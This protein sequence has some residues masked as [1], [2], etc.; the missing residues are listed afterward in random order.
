M[1]FSPP[2]MSQKLNQLESYESI[3]RP[4]LYN[5]C[6]D[7][8][9]DSFK[10]MEKDFEIK[11]NLK[12]FCNCYIDEIA[13]IY[14]REEIL[15]FDQWVDDV[16][17]TDKEFEN[18]FFENATEDTDIKFKTDLFDICMENMTPLL[19]DYYEKSS[20]ICDCFSDKVA[21][22]ANDNETNA[23]QLK[24]PTTIE[25]IFFSCSNEIIYQKSNTENIYNPADIIGSKERIEV[26]LNKFYGNS[27]LVGIEIGGV[28]NYFMVDT[29]ASDLI[30]NKEIEQHLL[31][32]GL[33]N[34]DSYLGQE[35]YSVADGREV[36][37]TVVIINDVKIGD[38]KVNNVKAAILDTELPLLGMSFLEKFK[39]WEININEK[40]LIL[41]K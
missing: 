16:S 33:I 18:C 31:S 10:K 41:Y 24:D 37:A 38:Y 20:E 19:S 27:L 8:L 11:I 26:S 35:I 36:S 28:F 39:D 2:A 3:G 30:I 25:N 40:K 7:R 21:S 32:K 12:G 4:I 23:N 14:T 1:L 17:F 13:S 15:S 6:L 22:I 5:I 29:G 34:E 9:K